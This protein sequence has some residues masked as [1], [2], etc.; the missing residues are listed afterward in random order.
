MSHYHFYRTKR[1]YSKFIGLIMFIVIF[2]IIFIGIQDF[3][4]ST[5][6]KQYESLEKALQRG[7]MQCYA[8]EG[9]Y[10]ES[11]DYLKEHYGIVYDKN[12]FYVDYKP[13]AKNIKPSVTIISAKGG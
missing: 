13:V 4:K 1:N 2:I 7:I 10:P 12:L 6:D 5:Y 9:Q 8:L 11:L 3:S